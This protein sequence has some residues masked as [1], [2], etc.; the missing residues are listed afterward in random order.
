M[1]AG[2]LILLIVLILVGSFVSLGY[3][4]NQVSTLAQQSQQLKHQIT[5][6]E[7]DLAIERQKNQRIE[8]DLLRMTGHLEDTKALLEAETAAKQQ[9]M[10]EK[11]ACKLN[12]AI[13]VLSSRPLL[14]IMI[15][16]AAMG[17]VLGTIGLTRWTR[18]N[19]LT[20]RHVSPSPENDQQFITIRITRDQ[21]VHYI[22]YCRHNIVG[23]T[24][25]KQ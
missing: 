9:A 15:L 7:R 14:D 23:G 12:Q 25:E 21:L 20:R 3:L 5:S 11:R 19:K 2:T 4:M 13:N 22:Q 24:R 1:K 16:P 8:G 10:S 18:R 17:S 6:L